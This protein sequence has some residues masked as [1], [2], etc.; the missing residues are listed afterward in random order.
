MHKSLI[1]EHVEERVVG[2]ISKDS[3]AIEAREKPQKKNSSGNSQGGKEKRKRGRPI[4]GE[5]REKVLMR[6]ERQQV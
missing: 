4:K 5:K 6:L 2:H 1:K 3:T